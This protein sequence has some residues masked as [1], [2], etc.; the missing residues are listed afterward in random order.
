MLMCGYLGF[1]SKNGG[2]LVSNQ[3][4]ASVEHVA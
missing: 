1:Q 4:V 3:I 2:F